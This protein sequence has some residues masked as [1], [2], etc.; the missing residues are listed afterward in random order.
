MLAVKI[1]LFVAVSV[2]TILGTDSCVR[3]TPKST[4]NIS[5][6]DDIRYNFLIAQN[7]AIYERRGFG[8]IG[9][10]TSAEPSKSSQIAI[11]DLMICADG[12]S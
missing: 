2:L 6:L 9:D 8:L 5:G 10:F 3:R 12:S 7:G 1:L 4:T 11:K